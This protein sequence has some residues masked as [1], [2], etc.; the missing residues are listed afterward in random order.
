MQEPKWKQFEKLVYELQKE[1]AGDAEV[2]LND[3]ILGVDSE[4]YRQIDISI[5]RRIGQYPILIVIDC[6]DYAEPI[7]VRANRGAMIVSS[8]FTE[9]ALT[10]AQNHGIDTFRLVD[11]ENVDW[12]SYAAL[13]CLLERTH[14]KSYSLHVRG[15]GYFMI[16]YS[17]IELSDLELKTAEGAPVGT[18]IQILRNK[19]DRAEM[20]R[21]PG[22]HEVAIGTN[23]TISYRGTESRVDI[24]A[25]VIVAV[26]YY[27]GSLPIETRGLE[28]VQSG[29]LLTRQFRTHNLEPARIEAGLE[30][31]W[32][33]IDD[34]SQL[35]VLK[36]HFML[37]YFDAYSDDVVPDPP[38]EA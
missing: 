27:F 22:Q 25:F 26:E 37:S 5:R 11:T 9:A 16:P 4:T 30:T 15:S 21:T 33:K 12:K 38:E 7:D 20:P 14:L 36:P 28:D 8:G 24:K 3:S 13:S 1:F 31:G 18:S 29:A 6:K 17:P 32:K 2:K 35:S 34:P 19:W 23:L 10:L